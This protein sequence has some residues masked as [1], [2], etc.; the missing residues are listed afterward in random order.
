[1]RALPGWTGVEAD[2]VALL[3][4]AE[5]RL[6]LALE[7]P[8]ATPAQPLTLAMLQAR[9]LLLGLY[10]LWHHICTSQNT[11]SAGLTFAMLICLCIDFD[12]ARYRCLVRTYLFS[13]VA[14]VGCWTRFSACLLR[15][16]L[17]D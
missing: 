16:L 5:E 17:R 3:V 6:L 12:S 2:A 9:P 11:V 10:W 4:A 8:A 14:D 15:V 13:Q 7:P 1:V